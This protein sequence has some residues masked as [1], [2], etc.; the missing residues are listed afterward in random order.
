L[1]AVSTIERADRIDVIELAQAARRGWRPLAACTILGILGALAVLAWAPRRFAGS[2]SVVV[3]SAP[4]S[5]ATSVLAKL[6]LGDAAPALGAPAPLETEIAI[7]SSRALVGNVI[8]S[9]LLQAT[10]VVPR[11]VAG[12]DVVSQLRLASAFPKI[13]YTVEQLSGSHYRFSDGDKRYTADAGKPVALPQG[14]VVLRADTMLPSKFSLLLLDR[15]DALAEVQHQLAIS[16]ATGSEVLTIAFQASDSMTAAAVPNALI[17]DYLVRRRTV[18]R[19]TNAYRAAFL[20]AQVDTIGR[21]LAS[22]EDSLRRFQEASGMVQ[23][24]VQGKL[25]LDQAAEVRSQI[26]AVDVERGALEQLTSQIAT[27]QMSAR[28]LAVYPAFLKSAGINEL[29]GQLVRVETDRT[30]LLGRRLETDRDVIALTQSGANI[31]GQIKALAASYKASLDKERIDLTSQLDTIQRTLGTF[32]GAA[33]S[34]GRLQR[35]AKQLAQTYAALQAQLVEARLAAIGEGG[36]VRLLDPATAPKK[37]VFPRTLT[38]LGIGIGAGLFV[39]LIL[40]LFAGTLGKY[41]EDPQAIERTT[42]V[43]ALRLE[44]AMPLLVSGNAISSTL[45]LVPIDGRVSTAGVAERLARVA[46]ARGSE[47]T[48]LDLSGGTSPVTQS[49]ALTTD[50][51]TTVARLES[52]HGMVIVRL[53]A[54]AAD[55]TAAALRPQRTVLFVAPP[56]R[57]ERRVLVDAIQT[58]RRLDVPCAGVVVN[59]ASDGAR[60]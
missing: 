3:K 47:P 34:S 52:Q 43:P 39:G 32:P 12:R 42:G 59:R 17:A 6:G 22:A 57:L 26:G 21:S 14:T 16:K 60:V 38:T 8:D 54:L 2:A 31:E 19:G 20:G 13:T 50:V 40:A 27:G 4:S 58:L 41:V 5:G 48:I 30:Q 24:E 35:Q 55:E 1:S 15:E 37:V 9:L 53:P 29:L 36:D 45:L 49:T 18:D 28:Q 10:V 33:E 23:P 25:Q 56:G 7:L 51:N 46:L 44:T 11:S